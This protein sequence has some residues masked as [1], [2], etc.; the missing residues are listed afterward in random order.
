MLQS[1]RKALMCQF[2]LP[3]LSRADSGPKA[4]RDRFPQHSPQAIPFPNIESEKE[5]NVDD[6]STR[7]PKLLNVSENSSVDDQ[8]TPTQAMT[9]EQRPRSES[10]RRTKPNFL[11]SPGSR[12]MIKNTSLAEETQRESSE[13]LSKR[14][15]N[16]LSIHKHTQRAW[17]DFQI[18][19]TERKAHSRPPGHALYE[20]ATRLQARKHAQVQREIAEEFEMRSK[21]KLS[22]GSK[23][24]LRK[25]VAREFC[26][27]IVGISVGDPNDSLNPLS[28]LVNGLIT[29][30]TWW[31]V[32]LSFGDFVLLVHRIGY[33]Q[34]E[35]EELCSVLVQSQEHG[36]GNSVPSATS[37]GSRDI[38][39]L[40]QIHIESTVKKHH[41]SKDLESVY[42][43][44][45]LDE[46]RAIFSAWYYLLNW[47]FQ[48]DSQKYGEEGT[49]SVFLFRPDRHSILQGQDDNDEENIDTHEDE[50]ANSS[51]LTVRVGRIISLFV[52]L[53]TGED[54]AISHILHE[55][56]EIGD[57]CGLPTQDDEDNIVIKSD[58][59]FFRA[60]KDF[61]FGVDYNILADESHPQ[62][63][64]EQFGTQCRW[65]S[66]VVASLRPFYVSRMLKGIHLHKALKQE[67]ESNEE[68]LKMPAAKAEE[69]F[70]KMEKARRRA[71]DAQREKRKEQQ[72]EELRECTFKPETSSKKKGHL[73][74][75]YEGNIAHER[76]F[77]EHLKKRL[78]HHES[79]FEQKEAEELQECTFRPKL[80]QPNS[81]KFLT[82]SR[83]NVP[84]GWKQHLERQSQGRKWKQDVE[85]ADQLLS[86]GKN[87]AAH[88]YFMQYQGERSRKHVASQP[89][90]HSVSRETI[91]RLATS[92]SRPL[93]R[94][95]DTP[96]SRRSGS[97]SRDSH[98]VST[99]LADQLISPPKPIS[100][101]RSYRP[102]LNFG[103]WSFYERPEEIYEER[104]RHSEDD[105]QSS[106]WSPSS[107]TSVEPLLYV[108]IDI[109]GGRT[110]RITVYENVSA[111]KLA[112]DFC[113]RH[114]LNPHLYEYRLATLIAEQRQQA[115][116]SGVNDGE[117]YY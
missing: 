21:S 27:Q 45:V 43:P 82:Q 102:F 65:P 67:P 14:M 46:C 83:R 39:N 25:R 4:E 5:N 1:A 80:N 95:R 96:S 20:N 97:H 74:E 50:N 38:A 62:Y 56:E 64:E 44:T 91:E 15:K 108:E 111:A 8:R 115:L 87:P 114:G 117:G 63:T 76:L 41:I 47:C 73:G 22:E 106:E 3:L 16:Q 9:N 29:T 31:H 75:G 49:S 51:V 23:K 107:A 61:I 12:R 40:D 30:R 13:R 66:F 6:E 90:V 92:R 94:P 58:D 100:P 36:D 105:Q 85:I 72:E 17:K 112:S 88:K 86:Q 48:K 81:E 113:Q 68:K 24:F 101:R 59:K 99:N 89:G 93:S 18:M 52:R 71:E 34:S 11:M 55:W 79:Y 116:S 57:I 60:A 98:D 77:K 10:L 35:W 103:E 109:G 33:V 110:E 104:G 70:R 53:L 7:S 32:V 84:R 42:G 2:I 26:E 37:S 54:L 19:Q 69:S 28:D 78:D